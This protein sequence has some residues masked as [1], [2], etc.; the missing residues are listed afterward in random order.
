MLEFHRDFW[1][2]QGQSG[3][4]MLT[5]LRSVA[6]GDGVSLLRLSWQHLQ[7]LSNSAR[8]HGPR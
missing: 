7:T 1:I 6:H 2:F 4:Q 5:N 8:V 3:L